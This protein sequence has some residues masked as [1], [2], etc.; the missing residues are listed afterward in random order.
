MPGKIE[1]N[2]DFSRF[3]DPNFRAAH[4]D[5]SQGAIKK[6]LPLPLPVHRV[7]FPPISPSAFLAQR[8]HRRRR[9]AHRRCRRRNASLR[10]RRRRCR[11]LREKIM[12]RQN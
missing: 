4:P 6:H 11:L 12:S 3:L 2:S 8:R 9:R 1:E 5:L 10:D 7:S